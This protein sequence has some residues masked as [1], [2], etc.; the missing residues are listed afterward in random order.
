M[1]KTVIVIDS[2]ADLPKSVRDELEINMVPLNVHFGTEVY[3][4]QIDLDSKGFYEKLRSS[5]I[6]PKTSQPSP[7]AFAELYK[8]VA[9]PED[10]VIS[11]HISSKASGTYQSALMATS[12]LPDYN[13]K[14][15]DSEGLSLHYGM[16]AIEL[17]K[18]AR[19]GATFDEIK[20]HLDKVKKNIQVCFTVDTLEYL[21]KNGRIGTASSFLG[22][23]LNIK[24]ILS[25]EHG[26]V[27]GVEKVRG[28]KKAKKRLIEY[29]VEKLDETV[30]RKLHF[31]IVQGDA[32]KEA[33]ELEKDLRK[34]FPKMDSLIRSDLGP[35]IG[36]HAGPG[37]L[38]IIAYKL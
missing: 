27:S 37:T 14:V 33:D 34:V 36:S 32:L 20:A 3:K 26:M 2:T 38:G 30:G 21:Q 6:I 13:I 1:S 31:G 4:D 28:R 8:K 29:I 11:Y 23:M 10:L 19:T 17:A 9:N 18:K 12:L 22:S 7:G 35:I 24:P 25:I 5:K 15:L 16:Q